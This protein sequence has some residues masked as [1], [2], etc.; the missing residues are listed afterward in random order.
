MAID[1]GMYAPTQFQLSLLPETDLGTLN[2]TSM[3]KV[4]LLGIPS[5]TRPSVKDYSIK[6]GV[7][8]VANKNNIYVSEEGEIKEISFTALYDQTIAPILISNCMG[9][10]VGT[11]PASYDIPYNFTTVECKDGDSDND[12]TGAL[13]VCFINPETDY[14]ETFISCFVDSFKMYADAGDDGGRLKMDVTLKTKHN[15][16]HGYPTSDPT[17]ANS[18]LPYTTFRT[19]YDLATKQSIGGVDIVMSG[20]ELTLNSQVKFYGYIANGEPATIGRGFPEFLVTG[21]F[22]V[23]HDS[24]T[25]PIFFSKGYDENDIAVEISNHATWASASFGIKGSFGQ[26]TEDINIEEVEGG[27]FFNIPLKF[28]GDTSGD[29]IQIVP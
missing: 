13:T 29:V 12:S 15:S 9:V 17:Y 25:V 7:G 2:R 28:L 27:A 11:S 5:L 18:D 26:I 23:K 20:F 22:K 14:S 10:A 8:Q 19:I 21:S 16:D 6:H 4:N 3:H 1:T 24:N